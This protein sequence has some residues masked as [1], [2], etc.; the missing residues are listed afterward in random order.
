M[1]ISLAHRHRGTGTSHL[2]LALVEDGAG[3]AASI[4]RV[5]GVDLATVR[6]RVQQDLASASAA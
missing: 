4:L 2:L 1:E 5:A 3:E 6:E